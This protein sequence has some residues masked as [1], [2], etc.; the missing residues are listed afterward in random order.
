LLAILEQIHERYRFVVVGYVVM[1]EHIHL[2]ISE[3][4][5]GNPSTMMQ[6]LK[7][8]SAR[9]LL[10][11]KKRTHPRQQHLFLEPF[12]ATPSGRPGSTI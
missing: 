2:L 5:V 11:K 10:P 7:Q 1:P 9:A 8:R 3:P 12:H 6:V 4:E